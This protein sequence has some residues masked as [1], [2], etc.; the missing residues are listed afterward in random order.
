[1]ETET[2]VNAG[3]A[4]ERCRP[5]VDVLYVA[6][7]GSDPLQSPSRHVLAD[8]DVV[9]FGRGTLSVSREHRDEVH[10]LIVQIPDSLMSS[11]HGRLVHT[12]GTWVV[13]DRLSKNGVAIDGVRTRSGKLIPGQLLSLGNTILCIAREDHREPLDLDAATLPA[14][15]PELATFDPALA[16]ALEH[17]SRLATERISVL[18]LGETGTGKEVVAHAIH[19]LSRRR[20]PFVAVNCAAIAP[21]LLEA[22]LFGHRRGAFSGAVTD[23]L[24]HIRSSD[25]G[26]LFLD[27]VA[28]L[29]LQAQAALLRVLQEREVVPVGDTLPISIDLRV[30]SATNR[31]LAA[32]VIEGKFRE[33]LYARIAG[34]RLTLPPLRTR[35]TDLGL[36]IRE[37]L[38]RRPHARQVK[39]TWK[40]AMQLFRYAWPGNI[41]ELESTLE[42][43]TALARSE[44]ITLDHLPAAIHAA[45]EPMAKSKPATPAETLRPL[46]PKQLEL[47]HRLEELLRAH[48]DNLAE[49]ART[50]GKDRAQLYRWMRRFGLR[51]GSSHER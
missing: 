10:S 20:G 13:D 49:V 43:A 41:R 27:E 9:R 29:P 48:D 30:V 24:G 16:G 32:M 6:L 50:L 8:I 11:D 19:D 38:R 40:A 42:T 34:F 37:L 26:T 4:T 31:D 3:D 46:T 15:R 7:H 1:V 18:V 45:H 28:E 47:K 36:L 5:A 21:S 44:P 35:R 12:H 51:R 39:V 17:M 14:P 23:R 25:H 2:E 22:E 33:D